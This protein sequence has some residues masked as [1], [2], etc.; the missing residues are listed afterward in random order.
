MLSYLPKPRPIDVGVPLPKPNAPE[1]FVP[2]ADVAMLEVP[3]P[4]FVDAGVPK[5]PPV[6]PPVVV[7]PSVVP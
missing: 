4:K 2:A 5:S 7:V 1:G 3:K 6:P